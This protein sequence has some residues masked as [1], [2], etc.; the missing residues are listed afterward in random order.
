[1]NLEKTKKIDKLGSMAEKIITEKL[2]DIFEQNQKLEHFF[3]AISS[4]IKSYYINVIEGLKELTPSIITY[5]AISILDELMEEG[6][7]K[8]KDDLKG[9][10]KAARDNAMI[11]KEPSHLINA[12]NKFK[13]KSA[14]NSDEMTELLEEFK[15]IMNS[16]D[17]EEK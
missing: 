17:S 9:M 6:L 15:K 1:M 14:V 2:N 13:K 10:M 11:N 3:M 16:L 4:I 8:L 5:G 12:I 7:I